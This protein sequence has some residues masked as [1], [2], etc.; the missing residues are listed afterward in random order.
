VDRRPLGEWSRWEP[1]AHFTPVKTS[2]GHM[3]VSALTAE[4]EAKERD[5]SLEGIA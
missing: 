5:A 3:D 4:V 1:C 2:P